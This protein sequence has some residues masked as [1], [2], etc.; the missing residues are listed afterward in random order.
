[1]YPAGS[2]LR[3]SPRSREPAWSPAEALAQRRVHSRRPGFGKAIT[4]L[5]RFFAPSRESGIAHSTRHVHLQTERPVPANLPD[6]L[7]VPRGPITDL[8]LSTAPGRQ[9]SELPGARTH[10]ERVTLPAFGLPLVPSPPCGSSEKRSRT[11][12]TRTE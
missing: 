7:R 3:G 8:L 5:P 4:P 2:A 9:A 6:E 11:G 12:L 1:M 10:P